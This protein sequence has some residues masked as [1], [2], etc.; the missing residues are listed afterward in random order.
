MGRGEPASE[1]PVGRPSTWVSNGTGCGCESP[2]AG[3][4]GQGGPRSPRSLQ[5]G[6]Q[7]LWPDLGWPPARAGR[8]PEGRRATQGRAGRAFKEEPAPGLSLRGRRRGAGP[9]G[10]SER[11][12]TRAGPGLRGAEGARGRPGRLPPAGA[13]S[14]ER[15]PGRGRAPHPA[16]PRLLRPHSGRKEPGVWVTSQG[17]FRCFLISFPPAD[18]CSSFSASHPEVSG[19]SGRARLWVFW[20]NHP[21]PPPHSHPPWGGTFL[22]DLLLPA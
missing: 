7:P 19:P 22:S 9:A 4:A 14:P 18:K 8:T 3:W 13:R 6:T 15:A 17:T 12:R 20:G 1:R 10:P 5:P 2:A 16:S 11:E 21:T